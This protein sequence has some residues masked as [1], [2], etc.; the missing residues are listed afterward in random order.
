MATVHDVGYR[1]FPEA[2]PSLQLRYLEWSTRHNATIS[3]HVITDSAATKADLNAFYAIPPAKMTVLYPGVDPLLARVKDEEEIT[4]VCQKY[5]ITRPY[6]LFLST[7]QPRKNVARLVQAYA[8]SAG[9]RNNAMPQLVL[10]GNAGWLAEPIMAEIETLRAAGHDII[11]PGFIADE[12][13]A[14]LLSGAMALL[15][16]SLYEGFG[17]PLLEAQACETAVLTSSTSSL[18][19]VAGD[20]ALLVDPLDVDGMATAISRLATDA[21]LRADLVARGAVNVKRFG[22]WE[23]A[24]NVLNVLEKVHSTYAN[25]ST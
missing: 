7:I 11:T 5:A 10:A 3:R 8:Q 17:F 4:A 24:V 22:W 2:H 12:D 15:Y 25:D 14:A 23:T 1:H 13:K 18:P 9:A 21:D 16:P 19:E 6:F 20:S